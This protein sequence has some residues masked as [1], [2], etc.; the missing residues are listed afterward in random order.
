MIW[1]LCALIV[2]CNKEGFS[3]Y[4]P[5]E[6]KNVCLSNR[7]EQTTMLFFLLDV[8]IVNQFMVLM[9]IILF[10]LLLLLIN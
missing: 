7:F 5:A 10:L 9:F 6:Q 3:K 8:I 2:I 4:N 1:I